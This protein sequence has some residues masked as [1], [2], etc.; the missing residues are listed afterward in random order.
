MLRELFSNM[1]ADE[2]SHIPNG[3][4]L[5]TI[6]SIRTAIHLKFTIK[7]YVYRM[8]EH[9]KYIFGKFYIARAVQYQLIL[10]NM[11]TLQ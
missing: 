10:F 4:L 7:S 1:N 6:F 9:I 2:Y 5:Y 8:F 3:F 11:D